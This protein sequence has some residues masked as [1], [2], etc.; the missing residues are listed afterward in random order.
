MY[1]LS[2][3]REAGREG[4]SERECE[5][6][7]EKESEREYLQILCFVSRPLFNDF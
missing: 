7:R 1:M 4:E 5:G 6:E 3:G 2:A